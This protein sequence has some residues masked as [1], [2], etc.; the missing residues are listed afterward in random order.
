MCQLDRWIIQRYSWAKFIPIR[1][2]PSKLILSRIIRGVVCSSIVKVQHHQMLK[3]LRALSQTNLRCKGQRL[4]R[5]TTLKSI[6]KTRLLINI[7]NWINNIN[8]NRIETTEDTIIP[9]KYQ[10]WIN[11]IQLKSSKKEILYML[12]GNRKVQINQ[13]DKTW[14]V[15][16]IFCRAQV[17]WVIMDQTEQLQLD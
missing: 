12:L 3:L 6:N 7:I 11:Q 15:Y 5:C 2:M 9:Y 1:L 16:N 4:S 8:S 10:V 14:E 17:N 13:Q